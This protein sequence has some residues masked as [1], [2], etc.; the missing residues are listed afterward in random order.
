M[1]GPTLRQQ[2][3]KGTSSFF[4]GSWIA[5]YPD[6]ENYLILFESS[7]IPPIGPNNTR[8]NNKQID[9]L[10]K[11][12]LAT[13]NDSMRFLYYAQADSIIAEEAAVVVLYYDEALRLLNTKT[14][15]FRSNGLN[16][17]DLRRV[18]MR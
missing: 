5:D 9:A 3:T 15:G 1:P 10:Y 11:K 18:M 16:Q 17:L 6:A 2:I 7:N 14:K 12:A 4:R 13:A 8:T